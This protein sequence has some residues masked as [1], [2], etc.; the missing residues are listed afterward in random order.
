MGDLSSWQ[1]KNQAQTDANLNKMLAGSTTHANGQILTS[2]GLNI[3]AAV[4]ASR[5]RTLR[6]NATNFTNA[7]NAAEVAEIDQQEVEDRISENK[8]RNAGM[9]A[10]AF[11]N[12]QGGGQMG[13]G[14]FQRRQAGTKIGAALGSL[15][16]AN[17]GAMKSARM[18][19]LK[20]KQAAD[21][22]RSNPALGYSLAMQGLQRQLA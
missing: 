8:A 6:N 20:A 4:Q 1:R 5:D 3:T 10:L 21:L 13:R 12:A 2:G 18:K 14:L 7:Q 15:A 17:A 16:N 22:T 9:T 19:T 11:G